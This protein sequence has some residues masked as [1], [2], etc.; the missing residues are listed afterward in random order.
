MDQ[1]LLINHSNFEQNPQDNS[2]VHEE[3]KCKILSSA[4]EGILDCCFYPETQEQLSMHRTLLLQASLQN[5]TEASTSGNKQ[6]LL[7]LLQL[8]SQ[9][10]HLH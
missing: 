8:L 5:Q 1:C 7:Y 2:T 4:K 9:T 3:E 6:H 10:V